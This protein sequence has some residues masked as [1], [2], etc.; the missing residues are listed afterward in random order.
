MVMR[1]AQKLLE[2]LESRQG[3][4]SPLLILTHDYSVNN[5][6]QGLQIHKGPNRRGFERGECK[7]IE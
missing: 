1:S 3:K 4:I 7:G 5:T 6:N 2:F